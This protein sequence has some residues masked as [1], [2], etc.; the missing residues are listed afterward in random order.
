VALRWKDR[1]VTWTRRVKHLRVAGF[2]QVTNPPNLLYAMLCYKI[3]KQ[4]NNMQSQGQPEL[5][6]FA[7]LYALQYCHIKRESNFKTRLNKLCAAATV[8]LLLVAITMRKISVVSTRQN[9][10]ILL[11]S[12]FTRLRADA[13]DA[14]LYPRVYHMRRL[15]AARVY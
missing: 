11:N 9:C 2:I 3:K 7:I 4:L 1:Y 5:T 14:S 6:H 10:V 12:H 8:W 13:L 15:V